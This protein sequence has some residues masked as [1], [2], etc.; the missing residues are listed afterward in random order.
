MK[1]LLI[2]GTVSIVLFFATWL[3]LMQINWV[4][5]LKIQKVTDHT[6]RKLGDLFWKL[7]HKSEKESNNPFIINSVDSIVTKICDANKIQRQT[8]KV[9][10]I[11]KD[12]INAF[13]LPNGHLIVYSGLILNSANPEELTGVICHEI[14]HIQL[15]HVMK[16]LIKEI[17]LSTLVSITTGSRGST[18][19]VKKI[20]EMLSSTAFDRGLEKEADM[21]AVDYLIKAKINP[22]PFANFLYKLSDEKGNIP[23]YLN[24]MSTHPDSK[25]RASY[26]VEYCKKNKVTHQI[27]LSEKTFEKLKEQL[28]AE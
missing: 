14:A 21:K 2:Q 20:A 13:A 6:E 24:W 18:A 9:H 10:V 3:A 17:G 1:K 27:V 16:K 28:N 22:N 23:Q 15:N 19:S 8:I 25:E 7:Y 11:M 4:K 5:V 12:E 26:I